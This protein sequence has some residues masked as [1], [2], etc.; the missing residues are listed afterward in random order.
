MSVFWGRFEE[1]EKL[2]ANFNECVQEC[3][4]CSLEAILEYINNYENEEVERLTRIVHRAESEADE[5]RR[6][7]I[8]KLLQGT[9]MPNTRGDLMNLI[10]DIDDIADN[11]EDVLDSTLFI[12]LDLSELNQQQIEDMV[13]QIKKQYQK[14]ARAV[15]NIFTDMSQAM[16]DAGQLENIESSIDDIEENI[17]RK[18]SKRDDLELAQKLAYRD[19]ISEISDLADT[20]ENA[21]DIIE[22]IV[23][24]RRG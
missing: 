10:E 6:E 1:I 24:T 4:F 12:A 2:F 5:Y 8:N 9:L 11:A 7:I 20:I 22:I 19:T 14:L 23:A 3:L 16:T 13:E 17:I 18:I 21:G 15:S